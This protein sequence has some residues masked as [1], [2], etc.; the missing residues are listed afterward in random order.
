MLDAA[1]T[2]LDELAAR[3]PC[4]IASLHGSRRPSNATRGDGRHA[5][6]IL[7]GASV[8]TSI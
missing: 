2:D 5:G 6:R 1:T 4:S 8:I 3:M 7:D